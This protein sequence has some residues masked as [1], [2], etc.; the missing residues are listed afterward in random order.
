M[1]VRA[2][3]QQMTLFT[4]GA[5]GGTPLT[6]SLLA[7]SSNASF[8]PLYRSQLLLSHE[9]KDLL[10]NP[11]LVVFFKSID[12]TLSFARENIDLSWFLAGVSYREFVLREAC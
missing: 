12:K 4:S 8:R 3:C 7:G 1:E 9:R 10:N 11:F 2:Q 5:G 6:V